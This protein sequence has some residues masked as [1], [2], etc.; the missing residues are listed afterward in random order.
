MLEIVTELFIV[1]DFIFRIVI[2]K[3]CPYIWEEM[4]LLHDK[5][6][7]SN[8]HFIIRLI[9]SIP[10][11][12]LL[13]LIFGSRGRMDDLT[14]ISFALLRCLKLLRLRQISQYFE[15]VDF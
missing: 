9:A 10:Q 1:T 15:K 4:W 14:A 2:R 7:R 12:L 13:C 11:S 6:T 3:T 8:F 5:G